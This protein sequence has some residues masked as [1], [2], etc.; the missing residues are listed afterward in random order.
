M[1]TVGRCSG[2]LVDSAAVARTIAFIKSDYRA[3]RARTNAHSRRWVA[4]GRVGS[5]FVRLTRGVQGLGTSP[6]IYAKRLKV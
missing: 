5:I 6:L 2:G 1:K 4:A 3:F